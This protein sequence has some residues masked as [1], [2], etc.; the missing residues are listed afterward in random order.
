MHCPKCGARRARVLESRFRTEAVY[1]RR[2]CYKCSHRFSTHEMVC[3]DQLRENAQQAA[4]AVR[5]KKQ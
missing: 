4:V 3:D 1:R 5:S 2:E